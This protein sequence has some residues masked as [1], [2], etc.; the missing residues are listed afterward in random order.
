MNPIY[1]NDFAYVYNDKW[2][3]WGEKMW[4]FLRKA[5]REKLPMLLPGWIYAAAQVLY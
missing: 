4:P 2:A 3:Y 1:G 5:V